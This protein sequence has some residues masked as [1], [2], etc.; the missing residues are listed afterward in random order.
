[1]SDLKQLAGSGFRIGV[2]TRLDVLHNQS[3]W[4]ISFTP[5]LEAIPFYVP[6]DPPRSNCSI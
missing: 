5:Q 6:K 4:S 1:M 2:G 3:P